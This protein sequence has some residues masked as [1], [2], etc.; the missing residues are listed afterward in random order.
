M[1]LSRG[2]LGAIIGMPARP[3]LPRSLLIWVVAAALRGPASLEAADCMAI[4]MAAAPA[5]LG[6]GAG[7]YCCTGA[8]LGASSTVFAGGATSSFLGMGAAR[9]T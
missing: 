7:K 2:D 4:E 5:T 6:G 8:A 9:T 3:A 1:Y